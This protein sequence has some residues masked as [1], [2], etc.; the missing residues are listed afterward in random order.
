MAGEWP[1][2]IS[3]ASMGGKLCSP[4]ENE[5]KDRNDANTHI[6]KG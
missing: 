6:I 3:T 1:V 4:D 2:G 5:N